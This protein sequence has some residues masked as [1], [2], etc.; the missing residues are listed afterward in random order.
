MNGRQITSRVD[1]SA[2][3]ELDRRHALFLELLAESYPRIHSL[4][5]TLVGNPSDAAELLQDVSATLWNKFDDFEEGTNFGNWAIVVAANICRAFLR[6]KRRRNA[7][8]L[9]EQMLARLS[10]VHSGVSELMELRREQLRPCMKQ[11]SGDQ[12]SLIKAYYEDEKSIVMLARET[13]C[14]ERSLYNRLF[15]LRKR[16]YECISRRLGRSGEEA[17]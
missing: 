8:V 2:G 12:A 10:R 16:L 17:R 15:R 7:A 9:S 4:V 6:K 14:T 5:R 3:D 1:D 11:L 13:G